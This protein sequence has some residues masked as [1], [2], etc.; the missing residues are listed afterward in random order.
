MLV[1]NL[2]ALLEGKVISN[3]TPVLEGLRER[4]AR[5]ADAGTLDVKVELDGLSEGELSALLHVGTEQ[6]QNAGADMWAHVRAC[7]AC[8]PEGW[9]VVSGWCWAGKGCKGFCEDCGE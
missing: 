2:R 8:R 9:V 6:Q 7:G 3:M 4:L 1:K 5:S